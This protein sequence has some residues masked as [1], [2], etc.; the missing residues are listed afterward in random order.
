MEL[1]FPLNLAPRRDIK[2]QILMKKKNERNSQSG[3][4]KGVLPK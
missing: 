1:L 2:S 3:K 4:E